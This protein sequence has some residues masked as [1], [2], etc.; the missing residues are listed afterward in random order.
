MEKIENKRILQAYS[1]KLI[2][3]SVILISLIG[4]FIYYVSPGYILYKE[5]KNNLVWKIDEYENL[6]KNGMSFSEISSFIQNP[7]AQNI[8][9][10]AGEK[11]Y[12][13]NFSNTSKWDYM[14]FLITQEEKIYA[15]K[16]S[17]IIQSREQKISQILPSYQDGISVEWSM[18]DFEFIHSVENMLKTFKLRSESPLS[19]GGLVSFNKI[20]TDDKSNKNQKDSFSSEIFYIPLDL[21]VIW[22]KKDIVDFIYFLQ[23]VWK[24][25]TIENNTITFYN[26]NILSLQLWSWK[27]IY[28]NKI[29]DIES[30]ELSSYIDSSTMMRNGSYYETLPWFMSFLKSNVDANEIYNVNLKLRFYVKWLPFYKIETFIESNSKKFQEL[31]TQVNNEFKKVEWN[32]KSSITWEMFEIMNSLKTIHTY[33]WDLEKKVKSIEKSMKEK[34]N[35][36]KLYTESMN[37]KYE[38]ESIQFLLTDLL[39]KMK[40]LH[41]NKK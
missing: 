10:K 21:D 15:L 7:I 12:Q 41:D 32:L 27:N 29:V 36:E 39:K 26:D 34:N 31:K 4:I 33:I 35:L 2:F 1:S 19:I 24:V 22:L 3:L 16:K 23:N 38:V 25:N 9:S 40:T 28:E 8:L 6:K 17:D 14:D 5:N 13:N 37:L 20:E 11:F 18:S 30:L